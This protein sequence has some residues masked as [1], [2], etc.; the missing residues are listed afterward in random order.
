MIFFSESCC[1]ELR[2]FEKGLKPL[3]QRSM[4]TLRVDLLDLGIFPFVYVFVPDRYF[5]LSQYYQLSSSRGP[6]RIERL[7][8]QR[9]HS[10]VMEKVT[11]ARNEIG[12]LLDELIVQLDSEGSATQRAHFHRIRGRLHRAHDDWDLTTPIIELS[13]SIAMGFR[14]SKTADALVNRILE[15]ARE[16]VEELEGT[17]PNYH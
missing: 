14:F 12:P 6:C 17:T 13:S 5:H 11:V 4:D 9:R 3:N 2:I 10:L 7:H 8:G 1:T 16:L 15:K